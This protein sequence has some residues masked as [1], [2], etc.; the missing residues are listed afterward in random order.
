MKERTVAA[1]AALF[2]GSVARAQT[3]TKEA[4]EDSDGGIGA[5]EIIA[6]VVCLLIIFAFILA[7]IV[8]LRN[9]AKRK[10]MT[11]NTD[12]VQTGKKF[13]NLADNSRQFVKTRHVR[14]NTRATPQHQSYD[15]EESSS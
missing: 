15:E 2:L 14:K 3:T 6:I 9:S 1:V 8:M 10:K 5:A 12:K 4:S 13:D 11:E 7:C